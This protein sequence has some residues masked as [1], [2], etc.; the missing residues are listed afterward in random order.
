[1]G[2][3]PNDDAH[4]TRGLR[5]ACKFSLNQ[6]RLTVDT[7]LELS[8][9]GFG[10][11]AVAHFHISLSLSLS[12]AKYQLDPCFRTHHRCCHSSLCQP[13]LPVTPRSEPVTTA[14]LS[15]SSLPASHNCVPDDLDTIVTLALV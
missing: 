15:S 7:N 11:V 2:C 13:L 1:M 12:L 10:Q 6:H 8:E 5:G 9:G 3:S 14:L 4:P